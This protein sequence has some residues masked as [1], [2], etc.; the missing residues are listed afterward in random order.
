MVELVD[1]K[2][3]VGTVDEDVLGEVEVETETGVVEEGVFG[4]DEGVWREEGGD[5]E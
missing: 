1:G 5:G 2:W 4:N 3:T